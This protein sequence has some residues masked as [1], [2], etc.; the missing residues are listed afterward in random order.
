[1]RLAP[2]WTRLAVSRIPSGLSSRF[3]RTES[4]SGARGD[5]PRP[6][7]QLP[8]FA[9]TRLDSTFSRSLNQSSYTKTRRG[10]KVSTS[11]TPAISRIPR[12]ASSAAAADSSWTKRDSSVTSWAPTVGEIALVLEQNEGREAIRHLVENGS[13]AGTGGETQQESGHGGSPIAGE[14]E[15]RNRPDRAVPN[16]G[17]VP[18]RERL[19]GDR[20]RS[21]PP[22]DVRRRLVV[23]RFENPPVQKRGIDGRGGATKWDARF[24]VRHSLQA[25]SQGLVPAQSAFGVESEHHDDPRSDLVHRE[26][27]ALDQSEIAEESLFRPRIVDPNA[28]TR[29]TSVQDGGVGHHRVTQ[30]ETL[31][32]PRAQS[33]PDRRRIDPQ[34]ATQS[35]GSRGE[36]QNPP[37]HDS[38]AGHFP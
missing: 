24:H 4:P 12:S 17:V 28:S 31:A 13:R 16:E 27:C 11:S 32:L 38:A 21:R 25:P 18:S 35:L 14:V 5:I 34:A 30:E 10:K 6:K 1:M 22:A 20:E 3:P 37:P 19:G 23:Q 33:T 36:G 2:D 15:S 29:Q 26:R 7:P 9:P 8:R